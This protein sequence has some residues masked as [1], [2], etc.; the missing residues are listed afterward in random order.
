MN[1][2]RRSGKMKFSTAKIAQRI[3]HAITNA[4]VKIPLADFCHRTRK[5]RFLKHQTND[6]RAFLVLWQNV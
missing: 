5:A 1:D 6:W 4:A 3:R 2:F